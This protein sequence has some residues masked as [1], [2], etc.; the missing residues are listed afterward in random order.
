MT[1]PSTESE[2]NPRTVAGI[3]LGTYTISGI[4]AFDMTAFMGM[5]T[6][7]VY[8]IYFSRS[9]GGLELDIQL[10]FSVVS[11]FGAASFLMAIFGSWLSDKVLGPDLTLRCAAV[12]A[13]LGY[14]ALAFLPGATGLAV[15]LVLLCLAGATMWVAEGT[16]ASTILDKV[17]DKREAGFTIYYLG[18]AGGAF[19]GMTLGGF[20]QSGFGVRV[21]FFAS[22][23]L[24]SIGLGIYI[25][26]RRSTVPPIPPIAEDVRARGWQLALP[27]VLVA[28]AM[29]VLVIMVVTGVNPATAITVGAVIYAIYT[30]SRL[31]IG[32]TTTV[33][34]RRGVLTYLPFFLA[35]LVFGLLYQQLFTT[36]AAHAEGNTDRLLFG[37]EIPPSALLGFAPLCT[38]IVA[39]F[40]A[41]LWA[42]LGDRQPALSVKFAVAFLTC[43]GALIALA[44]SATSGTNT[45]LFLLASIVFVFG[46]A[47]MVL[48][49]SGISLATEAAPAGNQGRMLA[50]HYVG[51]AIGTAAAGTFA[52]HF[53]PGVTEGTYFTSFGLLG[54]LVAVGMIALRIVYRKRIAP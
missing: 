36:I 52:E 29:V 42:K 11:A 3:P 17:P 18:S 44:I 43:G 15:G 54:L 23:I 16:L 20:L 5:Q 48:S 30:F 10:A 25:L 2:T 13:V 45:P 34:E 9:D 28:M 21:G 50:L 14:L 26:S 40:L 47:D 1:L 53:E 22:A 51:V 8:F 32:K 37:I 27:L 24:L 33:E 46:A 19:V 4:S 39:P 7:L 35:T 6:L 31:L 49:P 12:T 41:S 38:I